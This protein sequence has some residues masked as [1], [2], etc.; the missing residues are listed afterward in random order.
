[1]ADHGWRSYRGEDLKQFRR[2]KGFEVGQR[3]AQIYL[4][5]SLLWALCD[6]KGEDEERLV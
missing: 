2:L 1:M 6:Q 5:K 3:S 4:L